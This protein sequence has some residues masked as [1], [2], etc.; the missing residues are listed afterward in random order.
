MK[1]IFLVIGITT[2]ASLFSC[3]EEKPFVVYIDDDY[4]KIL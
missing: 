2:M 1:K 4:P 3:G